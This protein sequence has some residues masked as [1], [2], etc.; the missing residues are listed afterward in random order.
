MTTRAGILADLQFTFI[1]LYS[2]PLVLS[3]RAS[4]FFAAASIASNSLPASANLP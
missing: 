1:R 2:R 4:Y 3:L